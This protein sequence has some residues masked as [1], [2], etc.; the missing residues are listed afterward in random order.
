LLARI[1]AADKKNQ[2]L[3]KVLDNTVERLKKL[4]EDAEDSDKVDTHVK[5]ITK[6]LSKYGTVKK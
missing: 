6:E 4:N 3:K 1:D 5:E 2:E